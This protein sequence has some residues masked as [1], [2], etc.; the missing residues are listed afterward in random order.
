[1]NTEIN[2]TI[3]QF[4][5]YACVGVVSN[6]FCYLAY[7]G[8]TAGGVGSKFSMTLVYAA[9][10]AQ[11]FY[12]NR[13]WTFSETSS[14]GIFIRYCIAYAIGYILNI[15]A[16]YIFVDKIGFPHQAIQAIMIFVLA[17]ILFLLQKF[18]IFRPSQ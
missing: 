18:W 16:L 17:V 7:I 5:K 13:K 1:M 11:T 15:A 3:I 6:A 2:T 9:G 12:F 10:V 4:V 8:L 14:N